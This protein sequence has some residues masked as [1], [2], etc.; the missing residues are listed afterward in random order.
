MAASRYPS[1]TRIDG[2]RAFRQLHAELA[3]RHHALG[4]RRVHAEHAMMPGT[5]VHAPR[6][7]N[8]KST[9]NNTS[10]CDDDSAD[11]DADYDDAYDTF[12]RILLK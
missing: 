10:G 4:C 9:S 3:E 7:S 12:N 5:Y 2:A 11:D 8:K 1:A 6:T